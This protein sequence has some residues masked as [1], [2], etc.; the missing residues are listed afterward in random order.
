MQNKQEKEKMIVSLFQKL[1]VSFINA[2]VPYNINILL[3]QPQSKLGQ[4]CA[5]R[6]LSLNG[7]P[8]PNSLQPNSCLLGLMVR[9]LALVVAMVSII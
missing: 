7:I 3:N 9:T 5:N 2:I 1:N 6:E 8:K 4:T